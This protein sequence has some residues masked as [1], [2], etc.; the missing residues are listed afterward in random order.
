[1][2][3]NSQLSN[4]KILGKFSMAVRPN[5]C[6]NKTAE[7]YLSFRPFLHCL[8]RGKGVFDHM[9][10]DL[11]ALRDPF[12]LVEGPVDGE[13]DPALRPEKRA[14]KAAAMMLRLP[15]SIERVQTAPVP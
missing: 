6:V 11:P 15:L 9:S 1:M 14:K 5:E 2:C 7:T 8:H 4:K 10:R 13:V 12:R 3:L